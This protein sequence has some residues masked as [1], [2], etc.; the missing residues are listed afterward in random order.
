MSEQGTIA[1]REVVELLTEYLEEALGA[2][3]RARLEEHLA[4][5]GGCA[6]ALAQ[7][8]ETI[9]LSGTLTEDD[10]PTPFRDSI[11]DA[12]LAWRRGTA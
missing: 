7:M 8:R 12:F 3:D 11:R 1:C 6:A 2:N 10:L 9:R 5:C 4:G